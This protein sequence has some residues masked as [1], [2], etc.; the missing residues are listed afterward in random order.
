MRSRILIGLLLGAAGGFAGWFLQEHL[1]QYQ[2]RVID[3]VCTAVPL[4][5]HQF[6]IL[7]ICTGGI[8]GM[9]LGAMDG[10]A[11][12]NAY[13][14]RMGIITGLLAGFFAGGL[15]L[16]LGGH[17]YIAMGGTMSKPE[18]ANLFTFFQQMA[19]RSAGM[20]LLGIGVGFGSSVSSLAKD[21][22][23]NGIIGGLLGGLL[24]GFLFDILPSAIAPLTGVAGDTGCHDAGATSRAV[25][26]ISIGA[27]T[28]FFIGLVQE[29]LKEAWVKVLAGRNEGKDYI[30][31]RPINIIGRD[32]KCDVPLYG[33]MTVAA[34]HA[35]I[36]AEGRRH[37]LVDAGTQIGS[38]VNGQAV[39][40]KGEQLLRDGDMIQIGNHR[41]LFRE[42]AT[43]SRSAAVLDSPKS[44]SP[45][46]AV[47]M[48]SHLCPYCGA[49]KDAQ[50]GCRCS[51]AGGAATA[52]PLSNSAPF[53]APASFP[54]AVP[55]QIVC[56]SGPYAGQGF[57]LGGQNISVGRDDGNTIVLKADVTV[58]RNHGRI[59]LENGRL[60]VYDNGSSNGTFVNGVRISGS[61]AVVPGDVVQ[62]GASGFRV[63]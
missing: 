59:V 7:A 61:A 32:E 52:S 39:A 19:A 15:G 35:A 56:V 37:V 27:F 12:S 21:R 13:R 26:F 49:V 46:S 10:I 30:L 38:S 11:E 31:T 22:I 34:Q 48:P 50:G 63:E 44:A 43:A 40:P 8:I 17:L 6:T 42:K 51:I 55:A 1:I 18:H 41:I 58:S 29:L 16:N 24:G 3:G 45:A 20:T 25:G 57:P 14:L 28:G 60:T 33:D 2:A 5:S 62:F 23:R 54:A 36:R 53:A 47:P 4:D 9:F